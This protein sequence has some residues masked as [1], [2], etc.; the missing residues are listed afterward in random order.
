MRFDPDNPKYVFGTKQILTYDDRNMVRKQLFQQAMD[1]LRN[2]FDLSAFDE[3]GRRKPNSPASRIIPLIVGLSVMLGIVISAVTGH[4]RAA[5]GIFGGAVLLIGLS[6]II[7]NKESEYDSNNTGLKPWQNGLWISGVG[8]IGVIGPVLSNFYSVTQVILLAMGAVFSLAALLMIIIQFSNR[9]KQDPD[10]GNKVEGECIGY[11][12]TLESNSDSHI[13]HIISAAV[14]EYYIDGEK[15][16]AI[17]GNST[18]DD[19]VTPVGST[20]ELN[21]NP[22]DPYDVRYN[23]ELKPNRVG[24]AA[25]LIFALIFAAAGGFLI[26][27]GAS[28]DFSESSKNSVVQREDGRYEI[29]DSMISDEIGRKDDEW[30]IEYYSVTDKFKD[31]NGNTIIE[32]SDGSL[33]LSP[34]KK[35]SD[36]YTVGMHFYQIVDAENGD[37]LLIYSAEKF[38]YAGSKKVKEKTRDSSADITA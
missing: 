35:T 38:V 17:D 6:V 24:F 22:S 14:F 29:T 10:Y 7:T 13:S 19:P 34:D 18:W 32:F 26:W 16:T 23:Q 27:Y 36:S 5:I 11:I 33:Q 21:V 12:R 20:V 30:R 4:P 8:A 28:H 3:D 9:K 2:A 15:Y 31:E 37:P 25:G 1:T